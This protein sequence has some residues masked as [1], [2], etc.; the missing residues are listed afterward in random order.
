MEALAEILFIL[1]MA[2][3]NH[4]NKEIILLNL[5]GYR[6]WQAVYQG[7]VILINSVELMHH[8]C[9]HYDYFKNDKKKTCYSGI[10]QL[11]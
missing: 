2:E 6:E 5:K 3:Q 11:K 1:G 4:K 8:C 7:I 9:N 10:M